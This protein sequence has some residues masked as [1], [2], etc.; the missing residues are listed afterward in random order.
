MRRLVLTIGATLILASPAAAIDA[1][2]ERSLHRL[3]PI[4]RLKQLCDYVAMQRIRKEH[5]PVPEDLVAR[6]DSHAPYE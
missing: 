3:A 1:R 5:K 2:F 4:D 6:S